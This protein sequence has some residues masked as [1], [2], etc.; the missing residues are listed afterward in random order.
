MREEINTQANWLVDKLFVQP[1][2]A[3]AVRSFQVQLKR[4]VESQTGQ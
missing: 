2:A 3:R 1:S 4:L